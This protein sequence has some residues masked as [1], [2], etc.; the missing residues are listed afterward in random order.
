MNNFFIKLIQ[1][2]AAFDNTAIFAVSIVPYSFFLF[3]LYKIKSINNFI[4]IGF[5]LTVLF[6]IITIIISLY[7]LTYLDKT[8]VE[9]DLLHGSA[10]LFLTISDFVILIGFIQMLKKLEVKNS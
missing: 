10:E 2:L 5:S 1:Q 6:V 8:L 4:K 7:T 3:F 9:V